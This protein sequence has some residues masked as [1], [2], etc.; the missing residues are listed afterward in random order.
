MDIRRMT[1]PHRP[2]KESTWKAFSFWRNGKG[3]RYWSPITAAADPYGYHGGAVSTLA[4]ARNFLYLI[5]PS[6]YT[7]GADLVSALSPTEYD[8]FIVDLFAEDGSALTTT[9]VAVLQT[10]PSGERRPALAYM[11][12]GE[13]EE[14]RYYW[15]G[16]YDSAPPEW[17]V[18][19]NPDWP[20]NFKVEY[21]DPEWKAI[22]FGSGD[23][24]LDRILAAGFDGV[25]L[26]I[27]DGFE[28]FEEIGE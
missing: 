21:W 11:S 4:D 6:R 19:E 13:A 3:S 27:I 10:K 28:Y 17:V 8:L 22:L 16:S 15:N 2:M 26:D 1:A 7:D 20:G 9:E 14:Y 23:G 12:I 18:E 24:Y 25:Y 5:N